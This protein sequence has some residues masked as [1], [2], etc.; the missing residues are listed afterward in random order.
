[1]KKIFAYIVLCLTTIACTN[2]DHYSWDDF[3]DK[4]DADTLRIAIVYSETG[5][6]V[7]GDNHGFV[8]T[9]GT[10]VTVKSSTNAFLQLE[11]SGQC[12]DGSLL[13]YSWRKLGVLLN[14]INLTNADGPAI[15]NQCG[16]A[17]YVT[18]AANTV[19]IL[20]DGLVYSPSPLDAKGDSIDQ[21]ATLFSEGQIYFNGTGT[22]TVYGKAKNGIASDDYIVYESGTVSV[23]V[24]STGTN[25]VKVNDGFTITGGI[26]NIVVEGDGARGIKNDSFTTISGGTTT[27]TTSGGCKPETIN[28]VED[29]T[30][31]A[32]I[33]SDSL[34]TMSSGT[35]T[36]TSSG[37]GGKG[38]NCSQN[39][40][41]SGGTMIV[42]TIGDNVNGKPK[43]V[44]SDTGIIL[45]GGS[46]KATTKKSWACD[47]GYEND[48]E[49]DSQIAQK[50]V[51]IVGTPQ[52]KILKKREVTVVF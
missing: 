39:I 45:S 16:K 38:I 32:G 14:G 20:S 10:D 5:V 43:A 25:G 21:K 2:D 23:N 19:S 36:I 15:N 29:F 1:M 22:L 28:G 31:C 7:T 9:N 33:K 26:L 30:S 4:T 18:T 46:F 44:K 49:T 41:M 52:T 37:D 11:L 47:N 35:L 8:T 6:S 50:R 48:T 42:A 24:A 51:T 40:E 34:F 27:I 12:S 13:I 17:F 3:A